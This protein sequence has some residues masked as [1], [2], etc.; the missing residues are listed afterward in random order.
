MPVHQE[1]IDALIQYALLLA[2]EEEDY[3]DRALGP[4][5]LIKYV[6]LADVAY[7]SRHEG[8]TFTGVEWQF[9]KFGPWSQAVNERIPVALTALGADRQV[10]E[11]DYRD[12]DDW[13]RWSMRDQHRLNDCERGLPLQIRLVL[14]KLVHKFLKDTPALLDFVYRT[15]PM[16]EAAPNDYLDF[17]NAASQLLEKPTTELRIDD[18]SEKRKKKYRERVQELR[19]RLKQKEREPSELVQLVS[20]PRFDETYENGVQWIENLA[21][22]ELVSGQL[23]AEFSD[24]VWKSVT[25]KGGDVPG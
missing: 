11:S 20:A 1:R 3:A 10:F 19:A 2:G 25:R 7:A 4:I 16:L 8:E 15:P 23:T 13:T 17:S 21:G 14:P 12:R 18:V 22:E 9:Y 5:H 24:D 6:Y